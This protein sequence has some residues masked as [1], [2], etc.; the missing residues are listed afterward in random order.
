MKRFYSVRLN[1]WLPV[2]ILGAF[3][4]MMMASS[5]WQ[6]GQQT[7]QL[8]AR[9][10]E[11]LQTRM[12][13][14]Q[15]RLESLLR[16]H[17]EG[18]VAEEIADF[19]AT[20]EAEALALIDDT[21]RVLYASQRP[22]Q[23]KQIADLVAAF[24]TAEFQQARENRQL[25]LAFDAKHEHILA[26]QPI[27]LATLPGQIRP[28]QTGVLLLQYQLAGARAEIQNNTF[29][30]SIS[31]M[32]I[33]G[34]TMVLMLVVLHRWLTIPLGYLRT[35]V[36]DISRGHF[37]HPVAISGK[38]ELADLAVAINTMQT[39][40]Q[41]ST[42]QLQASYE[43]LRAS[44]ENLQVT[45]NSIGDAVMTTDIDGRVTR[46]NPVAQNLTG[47]L[48]EEATGQ[49]LTSVFHI[50]NTQSRMLVANP[51]DR[52]LA[53]GE[54]VGLANHTSLISR[55]GQ[56]Y[57]IADS[58]APIRD[59]SGNTIGVVLVFHDVSEAYH[60]QALIAASEAELRKI[61][62]ILPGPVTRVD[63]DGRYLFVSDV[64]EAWYG[65]PAADVIGLTQAEVIGPELYE[66][67]APYC[68][69]ALA[70]ES[71]TFEITQPNT[72]G[73]E[74]HALAN[75]VPDYD[76]EGRVQGFYTICMDITLRIQA[77]QE[78]RN[79]RD[80]L[81]HATKMEA[82]GQLTSGIAHDFNNILGAMLGYTELTQHVIAAGKT[83]DIDAYLN[84]IL[85]AGNRAKELIAQM[86][87]FSRKSTRAT[88][89]IPVIRL[90]PVVKEVVTM[91]RSSIPSTIDLN[92][93]IADDNIMAP[94]HAVHLH[95]IIVNLGI[96]ARDAID[97]YG[98]INIMLSSCHFD[99]ASCTSCKHSFSGDYAQLTVR[100]NGHGITSE[101]LDKIFDPFFTTKSV[102]KGTGMG[103]S[104][105]HG[106]V[107][108]VGGHICVESD[109]SG[110]SINVLLPLAVMQS[111]NE[112]QSQ[113]NNFPGSPELLEGIRI[114]IVDDEPEMG[115]MLCEILSMQG[116]HVD[117]F[118]NPLEALSSFENNHQAINL[119]I[120]DETMPGLSGMHL[121]QRMLAI[122]ASLPIILYTG[123]SE[124][125]TAEAA[126][127]IGL[128]GFF[129]K[130][131]KMNDLLQK[132]QQVLQIKNA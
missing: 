18:L 66:P 62:N 108:S 49:P 59:K 28:T 81:L 63:R 87:T 107:H 56:E 16:L 40:L 6:Y 98:N 64:F 115:K 72:A 14:M 46:L 27:S 12:A 67:Y 106:L 13:N 60:K 32:T 31:D 97:E 5:I 129:Y 57:Q 73:G 21:G 101:I 37:N 117:T 125:A 116:A 82:V 29:S 99:A 15:H 88:D 95:Q 86:L 132:L 119:V 112:Q 4:A 36:E 65:K 90:A 35:V 41:H 22:W 85:K 24:N 19:G 55:H 80:Q 23:G 50:I 102:G 131:V 51:V 105:I 120:T 118:C 26:Y 78:A 93:Q 58:A 75:L 44:Q 43:E 1:L 48:P 38:G 94:I 30:R 123:Y 110:S 17:E 11:M 45:L 42:Q 130:P 113:P 34:L 128:A 124:H 10:T 74:R 2:L 54:I 84:A 114:M 77:E 89:D 8:E 111:A 69:R 92:Y 20:P 126:A 33:G 122:K 9:T 100:D 68:Q 71:V 91:L 39:D 70:G 127:A 96:N 121:A 103:L 47:W 83:E 7:S 61:T 25:R 109:S 104:V 53:S 79:L 3:M 52:V 76:N